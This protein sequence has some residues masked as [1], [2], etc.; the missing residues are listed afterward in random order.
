MLGHCP[1]CQVWTRESACFHCGGTLLYGI[2]D[3][4]GTGSHRYDPTTTRVLLC[5]HW[6]QIQIGVLS[7]P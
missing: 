6:Q 3:V 5:G 4:W 2:H 7:L 1:T